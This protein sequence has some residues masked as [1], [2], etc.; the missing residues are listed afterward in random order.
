[1]NQFFK[2]LLTV[3]SVKDLIVLILTL[4]DLP[5][6]GDIFG[7]IILHYGCPSSKRTTKLYLQKTLHK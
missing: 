5:G 3:R 1:M 2:K 4:V 7:P 6:F